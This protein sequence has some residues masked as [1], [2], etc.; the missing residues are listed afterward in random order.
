MTSTTAPT[1]L[2]DQRKLKLLFLHGYTR[3][4]PHFSIKTK[5]LQKALHKAFPAAPHPHAHPSYLG[6]VDCVFLTGPWRIRDVNDSQKASLL[7]EDPAAKDDEG[8]KADINTSVARAPTAS[9]LFWTGSST[10]SVSDPS[11]EENNCYAWWSKDS[12]TGEYTGLSDTLPVVGEF[13]RKNGPFQ[14]VIGFSQ[15]AC[16]AGILASILPPSDRDDSRLDRRT[17]IMKAS[18]GREHAFAWPSIFDD[19]STIPPLVFAVS[20]GGFRADDVL[21]S[22]ETGKLESV[23]RYQA[24]YEPPITTPMLH[25]IGL[26]DVVVDEK[27]SMGLVRACAVGQRK[28]IAGTSTAQRVDKQMQ[29]DL[30]E[31]ER[32]VVRFNGGH[33]VP[34]GKKDVE[35]LIRFMKEQLD[36]AFVTTQDSS[37]YAPAGKL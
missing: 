17:R 36:N 5:S 19:E 37:Y 24:L 8:Q 28:A 13:M 29:S 26:L 11:E 7:R 15:G 20:Y 18:E 34:Q 4:G 22:S 12:R 9:D 33:F 10:T 6:G 32:R 27:R 30:E 2:P 16:L 35:V 1:S 23:G 21:R 25:H 14:A 31:A 3:S